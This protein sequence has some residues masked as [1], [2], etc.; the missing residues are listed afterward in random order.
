MPSSLS[1]DLL[2]PSSG[3]ARR[4]R[5]YGDQADRSRVKAQPLPRGAQGISD[6][7]R[8]EGVAEFE[9]LDLIP[10]R[11]SASDLR[12]SLPAR[13]GEREVLFQTSGDANHM[14]EMPTTMRPM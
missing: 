9:A 8:L 11:R 14:A 7:T 5:A 13:K 1:W 4:S 12:R 3:S 2:W 6:A 10:A